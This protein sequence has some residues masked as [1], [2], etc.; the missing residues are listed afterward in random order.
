MSWLPSNEIESIRAALA[1]RG[2][3]A[4]APLLLVAASLP[5]GSTMLM[6]FG[7]RIE[8]G[9]D[10]QR[11]LMICGTFQINGDA[12][13]SDGLAR[14]TIEKSFAVGE[15]HPFGV[16]VRIDLEVAIMAGA[17]LSNSLKRGTSSIERASAYRYLRA[18]VVDADETVRGLPVDPHRE[19]ISGPAVGLEARLVAE[20][21]LGRTGLIGAGGRAVSRDYVRAMLAACNR[22]QKR[23]FPELRQVVRD[24]SV[25]RGGAGARSERARA[26]T[27]LPSIA[28]AIAVAEHE[29][30][31]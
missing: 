3:R 5:A 19:G 18:L 10:R 14:L 17:R 1:A 11:E 7:D 12:A 6:R 25:R 13:P 8:T 16:A 22:L 23:V 27:F 26:A 30:I 2:Y 15:E 9:R 4:A 29:T 24:L 31:Q 21:A 20:L 28:P